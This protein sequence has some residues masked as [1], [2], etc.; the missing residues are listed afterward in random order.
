MTKTQ[1]DR[2]ST[3][4]TT[5]VALERAFRDEYG[6]V[7]ATL[8]RQ[9]GDFELAEDAVQ[10]AFLVAMAAW[11]DGTVPANPGAWL[12]T[13]ARRKA[14]DRLRRAANYAKKQKELEYLVELDR[15]GRE[16]VDIA[17]PEAIDDDRLKLVFTCCHPALAL[18]AQVALTLKT[19]GGLTTREIA[20]GFL[21]AEATMAQRIVRAKRKI[22]AAGIPFRV[23]DEATLGERLSAVLAV[24]YLVF[25]EGYAASA[26]ADLVRTELCAEA[27]RLGT[28]L[29]ELVP[30]EPEV[31]GL[32]ALMMFHDSRRRARV[33]D[34]RLILLEDQDRALWDH[35]EIRAAS[36][37]LDRAVRLRRPGP[38]QLQAAIASLHATSPHPDGTDWP[39]I[40]ALYDE[41]RRL[42]P[43]AVVALNRAVAHAMADGPVVGLR[44]L[45]EVGEELETYHLF[46]AARADLLRRAGQ[47]S[48]AAAAYER[49]LAMAENDVERAFLRQRLAEVGSGTV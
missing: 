30:E 38:Y 28:V 11:S 16:G 18:D 46:H 19:L 31:L 21:V 49:A 48:A 9:I 10:E 29:V 24:I 35:D 41:L 8:I 2:A 43:T 44:M 15:Q 13:T 42:L 34:G 20:G 12:T 7:V 47:L 40:A 36:A 5:Q 4:A 25:N 1:G 33:V 26:G 45:D 37:L 3:A 23:P 17:D 14:I 22:R 39:Q 32:T 27:I 6:K